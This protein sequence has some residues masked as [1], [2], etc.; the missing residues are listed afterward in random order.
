MND[1]VPVQRLPEGESGKIIGCLTVEVIEAV[2]AVYALPE[3][4]RRKKIGNDDA[5]V[6]YLAGRYGISPALARRAKRDKRVRKLRDEFLKEAVE[7]LWPTIVH[8]MIGHVMT[9]RDPE[10]P[11]MALAKSFGKGGESGV[12]VN[13]NSNNRTIVMADGGIQEDR[14]NLLWLKETVESGLA[15]R[16]ISQLHSRAVDVPV[17]SVEEDG[18]AA[19]ADPPAPARVGEAGNGAAPSGPETP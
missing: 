17:E 9:A 6:R 11:F 16:L 8:R 18:S 7:D 13:V 1:L 2:A 4:V 10:R 3:Q 15:Q 5:V 12:Q 14:E 19:K